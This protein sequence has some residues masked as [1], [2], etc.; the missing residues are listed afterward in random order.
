[1]YLSYVKEVP[2]KF[3]TIDQPPTQALRVTS[4]KGDRATGDEREARGSTGSKKNSF[5]SL[6]LSRSLPPLRA[7]FFKRRE[8][9][10]R[11]RNKAVSE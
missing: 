6:P 10:V 9:W 4:T 5:H 2:N 1:M 11:G 3:N 7:H 8:V